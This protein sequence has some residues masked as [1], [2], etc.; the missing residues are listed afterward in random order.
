MSGHQSRSGRFGEKKMIY[1]TGTRTPTPLV[2]QP[3]ASL[4]T[5]YVIM[6][7]VANVLKQFSI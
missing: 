4:Y 2:I 1:P 3:V 7:S 6:C 5:D